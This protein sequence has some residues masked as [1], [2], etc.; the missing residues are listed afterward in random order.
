MFHH[1]M[2]HTG[3]RRTLYNIQQ[4]YFWPGMND[5]INTFVKEC[6][7]CGRRKAWNAKAKVP[8]QT[9]SPAE[10]PFSRT[11]I[12]LTGPFPTTKYGSK[13]V[14]ILKC[15][16]TKWVEIFAIPDKTAL[17]VAHCLVDEVYFRHGAP[18][19]LI[20]DRGKEF[21]NEL[22]AEVEKLMGVG[23]HIYT[24]PVNPRSDGM[25]EIQ[26]KTFKDGISSHIAKHQTDW[27]EYLSVVAFAYRCTINS[28][29]GYTPFY[30]LY[31]REPT[32]PTLDQLQSM[33]ISISDYTKN[34][35][36]A[37]V[38]TWESLSTRLVEDAIKTH[39]PN[40]IR[41]PIQFKTYVLG[42]LFYLSNYVKKR[43]YKDAKINRSLQLRYSGPYKIT[44]VFSPVL[45]QADI[46][47]KLKVVHAINM[48]KY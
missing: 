7:Y 47:K 45:Y 28:A 30:M 26:M 22:M 27:D 44:K 34:L 20:S 36:S 48:K 2:A 37:L 6:R 17:E 35:R 23:R 42:E 25:A 10:R 43:F 41:R 13:Y 40:K 32:A 19:V 14:L 12:D 1:G 33:D 3:R 11:H 31:G 18:R 21:M 16:L 9:Y 38:D 15:A 8:I 4:S 39:A 24:T 46:H 29:T 5:D